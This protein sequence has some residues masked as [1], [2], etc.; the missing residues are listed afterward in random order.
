[1]QVHLNIGLA[2]AGQSNIGPGTVLREL[3][4][5]GFSVVRNVVR[6]SDTEPTVVAECLV[7]DA[8]LGAGYSGLKSMVDFLAKLCGQE[9]IA[10]WIPEREVGLLAGPNADAWGQFNPEFFLTYDGARLSEVA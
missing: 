8:L 5:C 10:V 2:R 9:A 6:T 3:H 1:M 7:P 4:N